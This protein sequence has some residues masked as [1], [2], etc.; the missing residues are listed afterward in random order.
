M[1]LQAIWCA[2][3]LYTPIQTWAPPVT[4]PKLAAV[5]KKMLGL[6][7]STW[8]SLNFR[9]AS[10]ARF[11][12]VI[13]IGSLSIQVTGS[14]PVGELVDTLVVTKKWP[15]RAPTYSM[16]GLVAGAAMLSTTV[17]SSV[18]PFWTVLY[19]VNQP[20]K[21]WFWLLKPVIGNQFAPPS[22]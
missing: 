9:S 16:F 5:T 22:F 7:G 14:E 6:F 10:W 12:G 17:V 13:G 20:F 2:A 1:L 11:C 4:A 18:K 19:G 21:P 15:P 8:M 3:G